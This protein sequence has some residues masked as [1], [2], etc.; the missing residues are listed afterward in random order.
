MNELDQ[1]TSLLDGKWSHA[2]TTF[3]VVLA[4]AGRTFHAIVN[5]G[6]L[7]SIWKALI[8]GTNVPKPPEK[9]P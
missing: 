3:I 4:I 1:L 7:V 6:G 9:N 2:G 8:Y 5:G